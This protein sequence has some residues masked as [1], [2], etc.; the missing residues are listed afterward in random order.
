MTWNQI[1]NLIGRMPA[2]QRNNEA[3][4]IDDCGGPGQRV[5]QIEIARA[6]QDLYDGISIGNEIIVK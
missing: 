4:L 2:K 3:I 6:P 1:A 5:K